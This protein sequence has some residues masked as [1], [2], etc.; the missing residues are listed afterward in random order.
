MQIE[1]GTD[2]TTMS[3]EEM[4]RKK[5]YKTMTDNSAPIKPELSRFAREEVTL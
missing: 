5:K 3:V 4:L 1:K 2:N